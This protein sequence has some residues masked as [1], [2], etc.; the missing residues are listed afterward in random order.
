MIEERSYGNF[1]GLPEA[2]EVVGYLL[3]NLNKDELC[4]LFKESVGDVS[5]LIRVEEI[6][7]ELRFNDSALFTLLDHVAINDLTIRL[8]KIKPSLEFENFLKTIFIK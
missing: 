8:K 7:N 3:K 4:Q 6:V 2:N 5:F 1:I